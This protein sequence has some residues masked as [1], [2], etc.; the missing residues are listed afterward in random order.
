VAR[1]A[2][3]SRNKIEVEL[4]FGKILDE[5]QFFLKYAFT[6]FANGI[7]KSNP[8]QKVAVSPLDED[9]TYLSYGGQI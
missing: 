4:Y 9:V 2:S 5:T 6:H 7:I 8:N 1:V 3:H